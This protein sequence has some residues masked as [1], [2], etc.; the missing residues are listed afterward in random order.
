MS[1][2]SDRLRGLE[3][4]QRLIHK[5]MQSLFSSPRGVAGVTEVPIDVRD[6][7]FLLAEVRRYRDALEAINESPDFH[8]AANIA[9]EALREDQT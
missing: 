2:T 6:L 8:T 1:S 9:Y 4:W 7:D 5:Q 3:A